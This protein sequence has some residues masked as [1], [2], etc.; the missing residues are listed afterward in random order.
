MQGSRAQQLDLFSFTENEPDP[1]VLLV[2][3]RG[4]TFLVTRGGGWRAKWTGSRWGWVFERL[5]APWGWESWE[6]ELQFGQD[7]VTTAEEA[8]EHLMSYRTEHGDDPQWLARRA[9]RRHLMAV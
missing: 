3:E 7:H 5:S 1:E 4:A 2:R 6:P 8:T 9:A